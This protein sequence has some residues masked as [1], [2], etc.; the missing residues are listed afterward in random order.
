MNDRAKKIF[1]DLIRPIHSPFTRSLRRRFG[2]NYAEHPEMEL[3][4]A[5]DAMQLEA[6]RRLHAYLHVSA[7]QIHQIVIVG[8]NEADEIPRL[9]AAYPKS[10]FLCFEPSPQW[11]KGLEEKFGNCEYVKCSDLA[12]SDKPG[13]TTFYELPMS[14]NGSLLQPDVDRWATFNQF[15]E[16]K[17]T[18][19]QVNVSTLDKEAAGLERIDLLWIDVQGAEGKVLNGAQET[20]KKTNAVLLEIALT[21]SPYQGALLFS[22]LDALLSK[23]GF[24]CAGLGTDAWNYTGNA[25]WIGNIHNKAC[26][27]VKK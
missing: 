6:E 17:L 7:E 18:S 1:W 9:R 10:T 14:G 5:Y 24:T 11:Y 27:L 22:E 4:P 25:L 13:S 16:K 2:R 15:E 8:A 19:F 21:E 20:L 23:A 12:L 3:P 26:Q